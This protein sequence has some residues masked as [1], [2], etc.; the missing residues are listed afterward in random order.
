MSVPHPPKQGDELEMLS[1]FLDYYRAV[2]ADKASGLDAAQ[3]DTPVGPSTLT[4]G[5]IVHH[6]AF[7]EIWWFH[8]CFAGIEAAGE[9][10][11]DAPWDDDR[12]WDFHEAARLDPD[13]ILERYARA[14]GRSREVVAAV[15]DLDE[16]SVR[17]NREGEA[18]PDDVP[19][20]RELGVAANAQAL[21]ACAD[22]AMTG[23][24]IPFL[25]PDRAAWQ[26][27]FGD[28]LSA[29]ATLAMGSDW[30][31]STPNV[32]EQI[33]VAV[34]RR[35]EPDAE[36]FLPDQAIGLADAIAAFTA[37][38]AYVNGLETERGTI[39][40]GAAADLVVLDRNPFETGDIAATRVDLTVIDG[41]IMYA[42][43]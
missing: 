20:F 26:Y 30:S 39:S 28:L 32:M 14:C 1:A 35:H 5:G 9:P 12:D 17:T 33:A 25:G 4:L 13:T 11:D 38:S 19:R 3:L 18:C 6:L 2:V 16:V 10:W 21:W 7:V 36:P 37:G 43:G 8:Q 42:R 34:T 27:P 22:E 40:P 41:E 15:T 24:T 29:G 31:V 23:M